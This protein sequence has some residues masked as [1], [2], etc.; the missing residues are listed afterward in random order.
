MSFSLLCSAVKAGH[1]DSATWLLKIFKAPPSVRSYR[2]DSY[3]LDGL[4]YLNNAEKI[5]EKAVLGWV[6]SIVAESLE[7]SGDKRSV[8]QPSSA[9]IERIMLPRDKDYTGSYGRHIF[10]HQLPGK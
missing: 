2:A 8:Y 7:S 4:W 5:A 6:D 1:H 9:I 3:L 10:A